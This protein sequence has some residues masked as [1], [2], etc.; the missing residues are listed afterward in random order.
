MDPFVSDLK[1]SVTCSSAKQIENVIQRESLQSTLNVWDS[2]DSN[3]WQT[4]F[5]NGIQRAIASNRYRIATLDGLKP[6]PVF[7]DAAHDGLL[8]LM[9]KLRFAESED[10][11]YIGPSVGGKTM[12][13]KPKKKIEM[14]FAFQD[15]FLYNKKTVLFNKSTEDLFIVFLWFY[16]FE[17]SEELLED[18]EAIVVD[19][20]KIEEIEETKDIKEPKPKA[21]ETK[22]KSKGKK[23]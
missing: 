6:Y 20:S 5:S 2:L 14:M 10:R 12:N 22:S 9:E 17:N 1:T 23:V 3:K 7:Y 18:T 4:A 21:K 8:T 11:I 16:N 13:I 19:T 15:S